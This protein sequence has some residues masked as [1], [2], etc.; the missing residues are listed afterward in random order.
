MEE[1]ASR[2]SDTC[3]YVNNLKTN[4]QHQLDTYD[5]ASFY[6]LLTF[7]S[8]VYDTLLLSWGNRSCKAWSKNNRMSYSLCVISIAFFCTL[9]STL[10][11]QLTLTR[12]YHTGV[13]ITIINH[14]IRIIRMFLSKLK[15]DAFFFR[16]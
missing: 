9:F 11:S 2:R 1:A 8:A 4:A 6:K 3:Y 12:I 13:F 14:I 10:R 7:S 16:R 5:F 15:C